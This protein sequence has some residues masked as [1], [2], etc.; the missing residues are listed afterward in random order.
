MLVGGLAGF[1]NGFVTLRLLVPSFLATLGSMAIFRGLAIFISNQPREIY[2]PAFIALFNSSM[3]GL[4][5]TIIYPLVVT[6]VVAFF[7]KYSR[8]G[9]S[10]R[11]IGSNE[12]SARFAGLPSRNIKLMVFVSAG[13]FSALGALLLLG[14]TQTG[15]A[16]AGQGLELNAIAAVIVGG[17]RLGGGKGSVIG[18]LLGAVLLTMMFSGIAGM[19]LDASLQDL[20]KG[21]ILVIVILLMRK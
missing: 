5:V 17:G 16:V 3:L 4:P 13:I 15:L 10:V 1:F 2:D 20:T 6:T 7:W 21:F 14:R 18:T 11:A 9:V 8:L 12:Q 19:G